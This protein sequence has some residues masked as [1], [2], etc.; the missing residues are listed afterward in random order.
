[1]SFKST[2]VATVRVTVDGGTEKWLSWL[3]FHNIDKGAVVSPELITGDMD[4]VS[5][6]VLEMF[7]DSKIVKTPDQDETD[8]TKSLKELKKWCTNDNNEVKLIFRTT[9]YI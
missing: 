3:A 4:S 7:A 8:F 1:M 5:Q 2:I 6:V 9:V